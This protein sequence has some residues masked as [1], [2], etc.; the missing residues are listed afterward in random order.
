MPAGQVRRARAWCVLANRPSPGAPLKPGRPRPHQSRRQ[1]ARR[2][3][4]TPLALALLGGRVPRRRVAPLRAPA[5]TQRAGRTSPMS[6]FSALLVCLHPSGGDAEQARNCVR[7]VRHCFAA[8][9]SGLTPTSLRLAVLSGGYCSAEFSG[10]ASRS[11]AAVELA[12]LA[13]I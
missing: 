9:L 1:H 13:L 8:V 4:R 10:T 5:R 3:G 11:A 7:R 12:R 6:S 2:C